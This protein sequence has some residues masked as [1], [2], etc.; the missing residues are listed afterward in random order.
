MNEMTPLP[1]HKQAPISFRSDLAARLLAQL[2]RNGRSQAQVIEEALAREASRAPLPLTVE[3]RIA[4]IDAI[5]RPG[6]GLP[7][8]TFKEI[9]DEMWD[10]NGLPI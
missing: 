5:V 1:R 9:D 6:H 2:T 10:E 4:R 8:K 7:G 3:E